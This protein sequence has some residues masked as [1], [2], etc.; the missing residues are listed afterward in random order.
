MK[1]GVL[2]VQGAFREHMATLAAI[3]VEGVE[4]R[5]HAD[6]DDVAGLILPGGEST[7]MRHLI[8]RWGLREPILRLGRSGAPIFGTC[9]G[10]IILSTEIAGGEPPVL[11]LLHVLSLI[12]I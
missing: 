6:L 5:L 9:A 12:H 2:A 11:P 1:I 10:M 4:V 7:T 8:D 3:G